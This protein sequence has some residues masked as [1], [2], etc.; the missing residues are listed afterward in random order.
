[1]DNNRKKTENI[2]NIV[3][4]ASI[5][6]FFIADRILKSLVLSLPANYNQSLIG[7]Y[8]SFRFVAN[9]YLAFS[10][11]LG[12]LIINI[13]IAAIVIFLLGYIYYLLKHKKQTEAALFF[14]LFLGAISNLTD[15]LI[16][17][18]V[19]DYLNLRYFTVFNLADVMIS[20]GA[21]ILII[22]NLRIKDQSA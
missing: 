12:G 20:I 21:L 9:P 10:L 17:G 14:M 18:Y 6:I 11:P 1:M 8:L 5:T 15:R 19:I 22:K 7:N 4:A 3:I 13:L 2:L 16:Y